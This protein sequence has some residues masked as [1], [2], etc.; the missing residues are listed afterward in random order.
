[1]CTLVLYNAQR[2]YFA[3]KIEHVTKPYY[4]WYNKNRK[5]IFTLILLLFGMIAKHVIAFFI[6]HPIFV[7]YYLLLGVFS[8][9]YFLPPFNLRKFGFLKPVF[10]ASVFVCCGVLIPANFNLSLQLIYYTLS[11]FFLVVAL[12][13]LF[14]IRDNLSDK[15]IKLNTVP[16]LIGVFKAKILC[17]IFCTFYLLFMFLKSE[18]GLSISCLITAL[19]AI[20][21]TLTVNEN[22]KWNFYLYFV[23]GVVL[24]Q[25]LF[26]LIYE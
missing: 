5:W 13:L 16:N 25:A 3:G 21:L 14:D 7:C 15:E 18:S 10:I 23:D 2:L 19:L 17:L 24:V 20:I 9:F 4:V 26:Y 22:R 11:Q 12:C 8:L 1:M 6:E